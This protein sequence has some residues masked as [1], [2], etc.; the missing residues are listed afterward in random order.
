MDERKDFLVS[1]G[2]AR[3]TI[4]APQRRVDVALPEQVPLAELLPEVLRHAG[5]GLADEGER[6]GGWV[7]R[8]GDGVALATAQGLHPQGVRDGEVLHLVPAGE[9]WPE[10]EYDDVVEAIAEGARRRGGVWTPDASR[11]AT[12]AAAAVPL[13]LGLPALLTTGS[14]GE[15][16]GLAGLG[17]ALLLTLAGS[18]ASRAY[19]DGRAG[20]ALGGYALPYA[21]AGGALLITSYGDGG[22]LAPLPW[23]GGPE[24]LA[25]SVA[26]LLTSALAGA[27]VAAG[28]RFFTAGAVAGLLG[29]LTAM[30]GLFTT[31]AGGAALLISLLVCGI[32]VL[33]L[34]AVR[35]GRTPL[36]PVALPPGTEAVP[37][38]ETFR[39]GTDSRV[40]TDSRPGTDPVRRLP[41]RA[42]VFAS[43]ARTDELLAGMLLGHAVLVTGA[44]A[45]LATAG[46]LSSRI[47]IAVSTLAL[48]LRARLFV[49]RRHRVPVL[50]AGLAGLAALGADLLARAGDARPA[51]LAAVVLLALVTVVA[52]ARW[53]DQP[54]S[55][56]LG[57]AADIVDALA[58]VSIIPVACAVTG[59]YAAVSGLT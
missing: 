12:L 32:G 28:A 14:E 2:L 59:L 9:E 26:V 33:P 24:L 46:S 48:L 30:T 58:V 40:G 37:G 11:T 23:L 41:E 22:V 13:G 54:P 18:I 1:V 42:A 29:A 52:G 19:G 43:V 21:F 49:T 55:P 8:R 39:P 45:V 5:V 7:L 51:V 57:R 53:A 38:A 15:F 4:S 6:H 34:L 20:V 50:A 25:G 27:G 56:Y 44:F 47:L 3:L 10:L 16:P 17:V 36:P 31:A 35:F